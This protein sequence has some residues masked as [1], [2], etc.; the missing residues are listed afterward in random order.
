MHICY[1][2]LFQEYQILSRSISYI[3]ELIRGYTDG[4]ITV[5]QRETP[6][7]S[8]SPPMPENTLHLYLYVPLNLESL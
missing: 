6:A 7:A 1:Y 2:F 3:W 4:G 8:F 5:L